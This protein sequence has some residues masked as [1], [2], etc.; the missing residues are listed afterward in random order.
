MKL[1]ETKRQLDHY[2]VN[3]NHNIKTKISNY[4]RQFLTHKQTLDRMVRASYETANRRFISLAAGI[5]GN[6][7]MKSLLG[8][9]SYV[10][11]EAGDN[12]RSVKMVK[13]NERLKLVLYDG[14]IKAK[15]E[16]IVE[17]NG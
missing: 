4:D 11:N 5:E 8:G 2:L 10:E 16:E 17:K 1:K 9:Y 15:I 12:V 7:P 6:S 3:F 13:K 14:S